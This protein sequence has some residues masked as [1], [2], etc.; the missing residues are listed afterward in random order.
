MPRALIRSWVDTTA[1]VAGWVILA[2]T[3][4][5]WGAQRI[6]D[7]YGMGLI[8]V[9]FTLLGGAG[10]IRRLRV[11]RDGIEVDTQ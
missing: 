10:L 8:L 11:S 2:A 4:A 5:A 1:E 9:A 6:P 3:I 7:A